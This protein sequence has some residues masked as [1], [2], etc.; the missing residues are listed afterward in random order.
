MS[1]MVKRWSAVVCVISSGGAWARRGRRRARIA[2]QLYV[3]D[4][5][6][7]SVYSYVITSFELAG[8][9]ITVPVVPWPG[10][11]RCCFVTPRDITGIL[12]IWSALSGDARY[13]STYGHDIFDCVRYST[14]PVF[15]YIHPLRNDDSCRISFPLAKTC[16]NGGLGRLPDDRHRYGDYGRNLR[17]DR[18]PR[19]WN[20][21]NR[22]KDRPDDLRNVKCPWSG[23]GRICKSCTGADCKNCSC[24]RR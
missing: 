16:Y 20:L 7:P 11:I 15:P 3:C 17:D 22:H 9:I 5:H 2:C 24:R 12:E 1:H 23:L 21:D 6:H 13:G 18:L 4:A 19:F 8:M 14:F 10:I